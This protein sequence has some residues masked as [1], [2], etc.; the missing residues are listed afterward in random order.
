MSRRLCALFVM[1][2]L[3]LAASAPPTLVP[4]IRIPGFQLEPLDNTYYLS[5]Q[6]PDGTIRQESVKEIAPGQLQVQGVINQP[7][8]EHGTSL[9]VTYQA[10]ANGYVA[11]YTYG[12]GPPTPPTQLPQFLSPNA[13][14]STAG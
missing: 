11:K 2:L 13:L 7:F 12:K 10:G 8:E 14:K 5:I 4:Q 3:H 1:L 6:H 9:V